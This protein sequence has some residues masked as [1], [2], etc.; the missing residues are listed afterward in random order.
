MKFGIYSYNCSQNKACSFLNLLF[1][2]NYS[3]VLKGKNI[4]DKVL[5]K[6]TLSMI[7]Y[8]I[9]CKFLKRKFSKLYKL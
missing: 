7:R 2:L 4:R 3:T 9:E 6:F 1:N 8:H 5:K